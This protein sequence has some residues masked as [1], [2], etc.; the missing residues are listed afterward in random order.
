M[1]N[2]IFAIIIILILIASTAYSNNNKINIDNS[3]SDCFTLTQE[4]KG[5]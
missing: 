2:F 1:K 5:H 4:V 3:R